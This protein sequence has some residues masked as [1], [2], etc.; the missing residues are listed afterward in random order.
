MPLM[1]LGKDV[2]EAIGNIS[3]ELLEVLV[4]LKCSGSEPNHP[5]NFSHKS[6][7]QLQA[8]GCLDSR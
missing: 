8:S 1:Y 5:D 2:K 3:L 7:V 6:K 4:A